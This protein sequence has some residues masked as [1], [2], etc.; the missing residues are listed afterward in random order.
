[1]S[2][3]TDARGCFSVFVID[4]PARNRKR[5]QV[6]ARYVLAQKDAEKELR[7]LALLVGGRLSYQ[8][9]YKGHNL[10]VQLTHLKIVLRYFR[11][12]PLKTIKR[13]SLIKFLAIYRSSLKSIVEKRL[14]T[15]GEL[16]LVKKRAREIN[17]IAEEGLL[18][19]KSDPLSN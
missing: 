11:L 3:F 6:F 7:A 15:A 17:K 1:M 12:F 13:I 18:K 2:G 5:Y 9:S 19:I 10:S 8:K 16:L 4:R 14:L